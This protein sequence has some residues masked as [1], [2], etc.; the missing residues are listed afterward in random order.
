M[1]FQ[2]VDDILDFQ[3]TE[4]EVGKPVGA[5]L[6]Q[7]VLTLPALLLQERYP[8]DD[9]VKAIFEEPGDEGHLKRALEMINN[10]S[11]IEDSIRCRHGLLPSRAEEALAALPD[12]RYRRALLELPP[13]VLVRKS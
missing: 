8:N 3:G 5:D 11:V 1:S 7:G 2:I 13:Y 12:T 9:P 4:S 6:A 10:S